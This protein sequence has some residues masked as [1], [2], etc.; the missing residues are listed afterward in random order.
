[1]QNKELIWKSYRFPHLFELWQRWSSEPSWPQLDRWLR[2]YFQQHSGFGKNDRLAYSEAMFALMR[3]YQWI[4]AL[5]EGFLQQP[6]TVDWI[7]WDKN[8]HPDQVKELNPANVWYWLML[9][10]GFSTPAPKELG[11]ADVR[12]TWFFEQQTDHFSQ[13]P[14]FFVKGLRPVWQ[15]DLE[16]RAAFSG[17]TTEQLSQFVKGQNTRPPIWLRPQGINAD[18]LLAQLAGE[19]VNCASENGQI[20]VSGGK[21]LMETAAYK[22]GLFEIQDLASQ[23]IAST[24]DALPGM[25]IWD[26]CAGAGGKSMALAGSLGSKGSLVATDIRE[27]KL[28]EVKRRAKRAGY[29]NI[30]SFVWDSSEPLRLPAEVVRQRGFDAVLV[31]APCS[32][33]G[34]WRRNPDARWHLNDDERIELQQ[35]QLTILK[36]ASH[37][38]RPGGRLVYA[39]C[40]WLVSENEA[41]VEQF[42]KIVPGFKL[43]RQSM[44]GFPDENSDAMF[45][46]LMERSD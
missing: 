28:K 23:M 40:S 6:G 9:I 13:F 17:W 30:R 7:A 41:L 43:V 36:Q 42:L 31:D 2:R 25:K 8:W 37:A 3:N 21:G 11:N 44:L 5:E 33:S 34:T 18:S 38:V 4:G 15:A 27:Y 16:K 26:A 20:Q 12:K 10:Q 29:Y 1:M 14:D 24:V 45:S 39:T 22:K 19:G 46:A 32:S 35:L